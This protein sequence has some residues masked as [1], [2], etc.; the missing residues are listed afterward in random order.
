MTLVW[1]MPSDGVAARAPRVYWAWPRSSGRV[2]VVRVLGFE[3]GRDVLHIDLDPDAFRGPTLVRT[4]ASDDRRDGLVTVNGAT[5]AIVSGVP[6]LRDADL[7]VRRRAIPAME[8]W[9]AM[10]A[11]RPVSRDRQG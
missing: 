3:Q 5:L 7:R 1:Q 2:S 4:R 9:A 10:R 11:V 6:N 8:R